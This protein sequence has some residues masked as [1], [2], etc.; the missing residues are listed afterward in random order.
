MTFARERADRSEL[1]ADLIAWYDEGPQG[2]GGVASG[3][4]M[5]LLFRVLDESSLV[6]LKIWKDA[7]TRYYSRLMGTNRSLDEYYYAAARR[8]LPQARDEDGNTALLAAVNDDVDA[9][10]LEFLLH[11]MDDL[12]GGAPLL[13]IGDN[14]GRTPLI[15][16]V[17]EGQDDTVLRILAVT[18]NPDFLSTV[19][20][21]KDAGGWT[22]L[23]HA[24]RLTSADKVWKMVQAL[25]EANYDYVRTERLM[26]IVVSYAPEGEM[27]PLE[28]VVR[29]N[30]EGVARVLMERGAA[31]D[32]RLERIILDDLLEEDDLTEMMDRLREYFRIPA[33]QRDEGSAEEGPPRQR[34]RIRSFAGDVASSS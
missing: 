2:S 28:V 3:P 18:G 31:N 22:A 25:T 16:A 12:G 33:R 10:V 7:M 15:R 9:R 4:S 27:T 17:M 23:N 1:F 20:W 32:F 29:R 14:N 19:L 13:T 26:Q 6:G 21:V 30:F 34:P 8:V 11:E 24:V 5:D